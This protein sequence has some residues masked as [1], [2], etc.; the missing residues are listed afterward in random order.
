MFLF[1]PLP[2]GVLMYMVIGN[3]FQ[4]LQTYILSREPLPEELQKLV[5]LQDKEKEAATAE[6]KTLPFEPKSS[7]KKAT[8]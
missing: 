2:A 4:T 3:I 1:F 8:G 6:A 5:V 7:K